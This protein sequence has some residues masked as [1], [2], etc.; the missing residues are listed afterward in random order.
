MIEKECHYCG[1]MRTDC[2]KDTYN[3]KSINGKKEKAVPTTE[4]VLFHNG[5]DR[6]DSSKGYEKNNSAIAGFGNA[7]FVFCV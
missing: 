1:A 5:L 6:I 4:F 3:C 7:Y 2:S